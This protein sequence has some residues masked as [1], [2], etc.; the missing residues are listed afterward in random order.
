MKARRLNRRIEQA[1]ISAETYENIYAGL[2]AEHASSYGA[3]VSRK[4]T[5]LGAGR[6]KRFA[7]CSKAS[8]IAADFALR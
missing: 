4:W 1:R 3:W 5:R 7:N 8:L 6:I 2:I